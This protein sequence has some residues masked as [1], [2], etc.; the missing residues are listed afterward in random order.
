MAGLAKCP[1]LLAGGA[2]HFDR[3][4]FQPRL[5]HIA[6]P[7]GMDVPGEEACLAALGL[8]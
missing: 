4:E 6:V 5:H 1:M 2:S 8:S 3:G 7:G